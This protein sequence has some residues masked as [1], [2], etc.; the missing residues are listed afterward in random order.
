MACALIHTRAEAAE[1]LYEL[2]GRAASSRRRS[3]P[4]TSRRCSSGFPSCEGARSCPAVHADSPEPAKRY[5]WLTG[6]RPETIG[7]RVPELHGSGRGARRRRRRRRA[8]IFRE[9]RIRGHSTRHPP[10]SATPAERSSTEGS[11]RARRRRSSTSRAPSRRSS[12]KALSGGGGSSP[13]RRARLAVRRAK[14]D[15]VVAVA[16]ETLEQ[17]RTAGLTEIDPEIAELLGREP[18]RQRGQIELIAS[19]NFTWPSVFEAVG[20]VPTNKY[21]EA[22]PASA[23]TAAARSSTRSSRRRSTA[24]KRSSA[25]STRIQPHAGAQT[26]IRLPRSAQARRHDPP[27]SS[28]RMAATSRTA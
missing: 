23:T 16:Q 22:I 11:C 10:R 27:C 3:W 26:N 9:S 15:L 14:Y 5:P 12:A 18:E 13:P 6:D 1:R 8:R 4:P 17:L 2:K 7:V 28:S 20:S 21:A 25:P 24:R 19:E